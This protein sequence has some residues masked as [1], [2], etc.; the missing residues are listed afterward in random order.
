M[1]VDQN[2]GLRYWMMADTIKADQPIKDGARGYIELKG[3]PLNPYIVPGGEAVK[4]TAYNYPPGIQMIDAMRNAGMS[5]QVINMY[6]QGFP[7]YF[8]TPLYYGDNQDNPTGEKL[9]RFLQQDTLGFGSDRFIARAEDIHI[10]VMDS[11]PRFI[12]YDPTGNATPATFAVK[13]AD[14]KNTSSRVP[15]TW[16]HFQ[17]GLNKEGKIRAN[18]TDKLRFKVDINTDDELQ[19]K[20][21]EDKGWDFRYGRTAFHCKL[22]T[23]GRYSIS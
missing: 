14:D 20:T 17:A 9:A 12:D 10:F 11:L 13:D 1:N 18:L 23:C 21:A 6:Y 19:D 4:I 22:A 5:D 8:N 2:S 16:T 15:Y 3:Q 7:S